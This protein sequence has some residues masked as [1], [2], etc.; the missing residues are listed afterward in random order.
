MKQ[1]EWKISTLIKSLLL[2]F[3]DSTFPTISLSSLE[4]QVSHRV[5]HQLVSRIFAT[6]LKEILEFDDVLINDDL[7]Q[8]PAMKQDE[9]VVEYATLVK[10][11][12]LPNP[13]MNLEVWVTPDSHLTFPD[14]V[15]PAGSLTD[16]FARYGLFIKESFGSRV[17]NYNDFISS[18]SSFYETVKEFKIDVEMEN[19]LMRN[20]E[21]TNELDGVYRP[22]QCYSASE[23]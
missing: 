20:V 11:S 16:D 14:N 12:Q 3:I 7:D 1:I 2:T 13:G 23:P 4:L 5:T 15:N 18:S 8:L 19:I 9:K 22:Q 17:Y 6:F 10:L 21:K